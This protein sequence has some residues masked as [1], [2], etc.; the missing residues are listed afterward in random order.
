M[1]NFFY[2]EKKKQVSLKRFLGYKK[3]IKLRK[4]RSI[5]APNTFFNSVKFS[6]G[7]ILSIIY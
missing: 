1:D 7:D 4:K 3:T 6:T 2:N 5:I